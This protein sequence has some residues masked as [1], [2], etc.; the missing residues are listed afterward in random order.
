MRVHKYRAAPIAWCVLMLAL[1]SSATYASPAAA[2]TAGAVSDPGGLLTV[3]GFALLGGIVLNLMPCVL[4][5]L[6]L[7][8]LSVVDGGSHPSQARG[9]ALWYT[10]GV[11]SSF[12]VIGLAVVALRSAG[13]TLGWGFQLQQPAFVVILVLVMVAVGLSLSGLCTLGGGLGNAS[14]KLLNK[15]GRA[16]DFWTGALACLV[17]SPCVAPFMG[18]AL[19]YAFTASWFAALLVFLALGFGLAL[20]F[21]LI[22]FVPGA[23]RLLPRPGAWMETFKTVLAYPMFLTAVWLVWLLGKQRGIDAVAVILTGTV[24]LAFGLW[25]YEQARWRSLAW[26]KWLGGAVIAASLAS[27]VVVH[28]MPAPTDSGTKPS[29]MQGATVY[30]PRDLA[31][32]RKEGRN[33]LVSITAD[34]CITCIANEQT[35]LGTAGFQELLRSTETLYMKGDWTNSD[36]VVGEFL[37][38]H[39]APGV[40]LYVLYRGMDDQATVL[41]P[42]VL[43]MNLVRDVLESEN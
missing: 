14:Q 22:G 27:I 31:Q 21:L 37:E 25:H 43:T 36:P 17:A 16:G 42:Q 3:L 33:V 13:N 40:P 35:V 39:H 1:A 34:W 4:P 26:R 8:V 5:V 30:H 38:R 20:P 41:L 10:A 11:V 32:A 9:H 29:Q 23:A 28:R 6:S 2:A 7:K 18:P 19:A 15:P 24:V 12:A